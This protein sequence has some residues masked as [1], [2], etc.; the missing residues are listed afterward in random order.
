MINPAKRKSI[1]AI[2]PMRQSLYTDSYTSSSKSYRLH[3]FEIFEMMHYESISD[4]FSRFMTIINEL[5]SLGK[6]YTNADLVNKILRSLPKSWD[7]KV[8][9][10]QEAKDVET[11]PLEE[12]IGS[13]MNHALNLWYKEVVADQ[14]KKKIIALKAKKKFKAMMATWSDSED[15]STDDEVAHLCFM[16][17][18]KKE[19]LATQHEERKFLKRGCTRQFKEVDKLYFGLNGKRKD[20]VYW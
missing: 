12:L 13:L 4:M 15:S 18:E 5:K 6:I 20:Y 9:A 17:N 8:T 16:A 11:L 10:I 7:P 1:A 3:S 14:E 19:S 2:I